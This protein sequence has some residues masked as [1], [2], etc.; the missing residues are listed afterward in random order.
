MRK[1]TDER[2][3]KYKE[4]EV[5]KIVEDIEDKLKENIFLGIKRNK[6]Y[7][8]IYLFGLRLTIILFANNGYRRSD[9]R[10]TL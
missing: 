10:R 8:I 1:L 9:K 7:F 6:K 2:I 4:L 3:I 5:L